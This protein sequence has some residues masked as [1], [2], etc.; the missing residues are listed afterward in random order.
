VALEGGG[1]ATLPRDWLDRFGDR[2]ADLLGALDERGRVARH[3]LPDLARLCED[4]DEPPPPSLAGLRPLLEDFEGIPRT[5]LPSDL[6]AVLRPYQARGID[7]LVFLRKTGL[8]ALLADDMGLGKTLQALCAVEGRT[9]VVAPTR[10][11]HG[12]RREI[13]RF[14]PSLSVSLYHG[15]GRALD[16][17]ASITI[18]SYA[19][20]RQD[21]AILAAPDWDC[22]VLDEAQMGASVDWSVFWRR[23]RASAAADAR[24]NLDDRTRWSK[25][26]QEPT[27][28]VSGDPL[29]LVDRCERL[30]TQLS[31]H[32]VPHEGR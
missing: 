2:L 10:V 31:H 4:L 13:A 12:W 27:L 22:V 3:A 14:R 8:G 26:V 7:W 30:V 1:F 25:P 16:P 29:P 15:P 11:L 20:L 18:T 5:E 19:L 24:Q 21:V 6:D 23:R 32:H 28:P 9:L 17:D